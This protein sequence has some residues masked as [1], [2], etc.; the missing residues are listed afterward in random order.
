MYL[1]SLYTLVTDKNMINL[2]LK[3]KIGNWKFSL[4]FQLNFA[5]KSKLV[6]GCPVSV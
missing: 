4:N 2:A 6:I 5:F 3:L 1:S